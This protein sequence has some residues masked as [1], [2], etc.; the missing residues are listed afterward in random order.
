MVPDLGTIF[1]D[2][3]SCLQVNPDLHGLE[4]IHR[5]GQDK[6]LQVK[7][8]ITKVKRLQRLRNQS[9]TK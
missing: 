2:W 6:F 5:A 1:Y 9:A 8:L 3:T 4:I 7:E